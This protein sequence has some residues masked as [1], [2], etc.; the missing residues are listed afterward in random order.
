M[1]QGVVLHPKLGVT[2]RW[3]V[4]GA[5]VAMFFLAYN[6]ILAFAKIKLP[7]YMS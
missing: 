7:G 2:A 1:L 6:I 4:I 5:G 3:V